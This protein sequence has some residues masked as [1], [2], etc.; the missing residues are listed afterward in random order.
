MADKGLERIVSRME[1]LLE[2][3]AIGVYGDGEG[4][5]VVAES[6]VD[7]RARRADIAREAAGRSGSAYDYVYL[8][9]GEAMEA[10]C[11]PE[12]PLGRLLAECCFIRGGLDGIGR[13]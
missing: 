13:F 2:P 5:L 7:S 6:T 11:D 3:V 1:K 8:T 10:M 9:P 4:I 12:G